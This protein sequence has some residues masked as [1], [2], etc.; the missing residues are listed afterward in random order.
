MDD[1]E[2]SLDGFDHLNP[3]RAIEFLDGVVAG[4]DEEC[5][6]QGHSASLSLT[7]A[8]VVVGPDLQE[9]A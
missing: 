8:G 9:V 1:L 7:C 6:V 5:V 3:S 2:P 4:D